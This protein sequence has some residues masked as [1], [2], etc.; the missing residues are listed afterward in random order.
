MPRCTSLNRSGKKFNQVNQ[1]KDIVKILH[2]NEIAVLGCFVLGFDDDTP[3]ILSHTAEIVYDINVD[4]PR[5][6]L[7]TPF[8]G[9][10]LFTRFKKEGQL[11]TEDWSLYDS[12]HVVFQPKHMLPARLQ[13][14]FSDT[15]KQSFSYQHIF[16][17]AQIAPHSR[18][19]S[20]AS[21]WGLRQALLSSWKEEAK[22]ALTPPT[23]VMDDV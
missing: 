5:Y 22:Q 21:N 4:L 14:I 12:Q 9:S 18:L 11:L 8:P 7:L 15:L 17:R 16:H 13:Q 19:L 3:E 6:A 2:A 20:L 1:Y 23:L 10:H